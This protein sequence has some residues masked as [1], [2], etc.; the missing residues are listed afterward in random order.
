MN[1]ATIVIAVMVIAPILLLVVDLVRSRAAGEGAVQQAPDD[2]A[3]AAQGDDGVD[4]PDQLHGL[5]SEQVGERRRIGEREMRRAG[6]LEQ[7]A[8]PAQARGEPRQTR[9]MA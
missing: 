7:R 1:A 5:R 4:R 2:L 6:R 9:V 3:P 8:W